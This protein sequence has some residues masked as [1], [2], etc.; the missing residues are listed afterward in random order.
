MRSPLNIVFHQWTQ[1][2][3]FPYFMQGVKSVQQLSDIRYIWLG[4]L[5]GEEREWYTET[6]ELV[7]NQLI[8]WQTTSG[9]KHSVVVRFF[10]V[11]FDVTRLEFHLDY[12][13]PNPDDPQAGADLLLATV[14][15]NLDRFRTYIEDNGY[16]AEV[17]RGE[18]ERS[19]EELWKVPAEAPVRRR[20]EE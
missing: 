6:T 13:P 11:S 20:R 16:D 10:Y 19:V 5:N 1:F 2:E 15:S 9:P 7:P 18:V 14:V 3:S 4:E 17:W 12:D 8:A